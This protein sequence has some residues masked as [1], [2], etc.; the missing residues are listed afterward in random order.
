MCR[1]SFTAALP[2]KLA[3]QD[4]DRLHLTCAVAGDPD[5]QITWS[6]NGKSISSSEI[7]DLK[8]KA[9]TASLTINEVFPEDEG[10]YTCTATNSIGATDTACRLSITG[11]RTR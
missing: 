9:G 7:I 8:Y 1:P 6:K 2:A 11:K 5:P 3:V 4:G 10:V